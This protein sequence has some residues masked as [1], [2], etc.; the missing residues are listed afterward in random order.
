MTR[1]GGQT[2]WRSLGR[3]VSALRSARP[4]VRLTALLLLCACQPQARRL[5][6]LDLALSDPVLLNGTAGPWRDQGYTV[7]YRRFYPHLAR[8]DLERYRVL[9]FLLGREPE[10]PSDALTVGDLALLTEWVLRGGVVVLGYDADGEGYL[11]RWTANRW[12]EAVG[13]G[14]SI[15]DRLLEDTTV[16]VLTTTGRPQPWAEGR[17][18][19]DEPLGSVFDPFPLDRNDVVT[20]RDSSQLIAVTSSHA[21]VRIPRTPAPRPRAGVVAATRIGDGLVVVISR[22]ALG[23]LGPQFRS[24]TA[25]LQQL[26]A[27]ERT[28]EFLGALARWTRR[29]AEWAHVPPATRGGP[30]VL[31]QAPVPVE[32]APPAMAP[33]GSVDTIALPLLPDPKLARATSTPEWLRQQGMRVLWSPLF[34]TRDGRRVIR[35]G[36]SLDSLVVLLDAGGFN[37]L[38]GDASPESTDS[39]H[40]RWEERDAVRRAWADAVKRLQP[41]SVAWIPLLD[42]ANVRHA[43]PDSS[44]GARG[45]G[46]A[47]PCALDSTLWGEGL[48]SAF[49]ALARLAAEQRTLVIALGLDVGT[50]RSYSMGQEFCDAAWRRG[51]AVLIRT[52]AAGGG[53]DSLPYAARY[54]VLRDAG[55][56]PRYYRALEDEVAARATTLR[57]RVLRQRRD[58]YFA[59]RLA[60]PPADWFTF[61]LLRGFGLPDRPLLLFTPELWTRDLL[62]FY[63]ARG[64]NIVHAVALVP[65][66]LR[67]RDWTGVKRLVFG[68]SDGF[69]LAPEEPAGP[70]AG[71]RLPQDSLGRLLRRLAR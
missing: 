42:Y 50:A 52:G 16:R 2:V 49:G 71:R 15:G 70:G 6:L 5:L 55:L 18:M 1:S 45:E 7:E 60:Q 11:D 35:S 56:L 48:P 30:L 23:A 9:L 63:R 27:L 33:P 26:D 66:S 20:T 24:T 38:A 46:L 19:G 4:A 13:T 51:L 68:E 12:L 62:A 53:W 59:F 64:L 8:A 28:H 3:L 40:V 54:P 29:P 67:A 69:W 47:A 31:E 22:H 58:L 41:T 43:A 57:D 39:L 65:P 32:L 34:A 17:A 10:A 44:R 25:P 14:I 37:L 21:F 36:A 61:G